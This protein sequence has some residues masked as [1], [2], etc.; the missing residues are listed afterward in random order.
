M[1]QSD[2]LRY[3][4]TQLQRLGIDYAVVG[5]FASGIWGETRFTQVIDILVDLRM[6]HL[7]LLYAAFPDPE[8]YLS[9]AAASD[10]T[11]QATQFNVIHPSSGN[12]IDFM[13]AGPKSWVL[14]QINRSKSVPV[15]PD[16]AVNI[17]APEDVI[18][19][20]LIYYREGGSE[21]HLRDISGIL[22]N[23]GVTIDPDYISGQAAQL[24]INDMWEAIKT[25][26]HPA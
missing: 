18:L 8:F 16:V 23:S 19:G 1:E 13:I 4:A 7:P 22:K 11:E 14:A 26:F 25:S 24:G 12:R 15:F 21:K 3:A 2:L 10:A 17:A 9:A 6:P 5:S 20:K